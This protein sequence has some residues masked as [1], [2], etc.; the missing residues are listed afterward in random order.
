ME[1]KP[2]HSDYFEVFEIHTAPRG[3]KILTV[4]VNKSEATQWVDRK[5]SMRIPIGALTTV[6]SRDDKKPKHANFVLVKSIGN[7]MIKTRITKSFNVIHNRI[8]I[9]KDALN[10]I[11]VHIY[12][13]GFEIPPFINGAYYEGKGIYQGVKSDKQGVYHFFSKAGNEFKLYIDDF[14]RDKIEV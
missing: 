10:N 7:S 5:G 8:D 14:T 2:L 11:N 13:D 1:I 9:I 4:R 6:V 3:L 12:I